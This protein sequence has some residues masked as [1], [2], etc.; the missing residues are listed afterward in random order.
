MSFLRTSPRWRL[1]AV[2]TLWLALGWA[3]LA[4]GTAHPGVPYRPWA[5][6]HHSYS[7]LIAMGGDRYFAGG[8]PTPYLEDRIEYPPL[9][10]AALW[11]PSFVSGRPLGF[12]TVSYLLLAGCAF[13]SIA[14]L[15]RIP[16]A[17][18]WWMAGTPALG[19]YAGLNWDLI[20]I[21][22]LLAAML[23]LE[24]GR[25]ARA[26]LLAGLGA[27]AKL[28]PIVLVPPAVASLARRGRWRTLAL[29]GAAT[30][31]AILAVNAPLAWLAPVNWSWF[32]R[33]NAQRGAENSI[34]EVLR[35]FP[36]AA[37]LVTDAPFLNAVSGAAV[38]LST[39]LAMAAAH[40][41]ARHD[42]AGR[43][44]RLGTAFV[45]V[46]WI[47]TNKVWSPQYA[48]WAAAAGALA[49]A[50][51]WAF[52]T[53]AVLAVV[54]Y[55]VAFETRASRGLVHYF[56]AVYTAEEVVRAVGYAAL[57]GWIGWELWRVAAA[58]RDRGIEA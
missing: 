27:C 6:D 35:H 49:A 57:A 34:W 36:S 45:I 58:A 38:V 52:V 24:R 39:L 28:W 47:A 21:A 37:H 19:Y 12:F 15:E 2:A 16:G 9:L 26:G 4:R 43:A 8:R 17:S 23:A 31:V 50:P 30:T 56:D 48:L 29:L 51:A 46:I 42:G 40:R 7:D 41:A 3:N 55:H 44:V 25:D 20:P 22:L 1:Y 33:F 54:D 13:L 10:G 14:L 32:W 5:F 11:L 53:Q 18:A